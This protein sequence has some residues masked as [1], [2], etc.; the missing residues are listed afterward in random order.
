MRILIVEDHIDLLSN[1]FAYL[2]PKDYVLDAAYDA[3]TAYQLCHIHQYDVLVIDWMLPK[4]QGIELLEKLRQDTIE[5]PIIMLTAKTELEDK[6]S[7]FNLGADDYLTKPFSIQELEAR[8]L[9]L[10]KLYSRQKKILQVADLSYNLYTN[11][12]SRNNTAIHL[13][14]SD[15]KLLAV[16]MQESPKVVSRDKLE[17]VLWGDDRPE[18][19]LLRT[20]IYELRKRIDAEYKTKLLRTIPKVGYQIA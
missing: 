5:T 7:C 20:H 8:I 15:K 3:E 17:Y 2:E 12:V 9:A 10:N 11:E 14:A 13:H 6:L 19:D 18:K 4:M 16:L 1:I